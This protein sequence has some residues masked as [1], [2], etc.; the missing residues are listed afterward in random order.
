MK[1]QI[2]FAAVAAALR[3]PLASAVQSPPPPAAPVTTVDHFSQADLLEKGKAFKQTAAA[4]GTGERT[5][6]K[7]PNHYTMLTLRTKN[8]GAEMHRHLA[9]FFYIPKGT[10][11]LVS[12]GSTPTPKKTPQAKCEVQR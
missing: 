12:G 2:L 8:G 9:D 6:A 7:Y 4:T 1:K 3:M 5:L 10:A 11:T